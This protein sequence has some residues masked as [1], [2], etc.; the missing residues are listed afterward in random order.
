MRNRRRYGRRGLSTIVT[1]LMLVVAVSMIG[2]ALVAW[3]NSSFATQQ[4]DISNQTTNRINLVKETFI[5]EDVWFY[6]NVTG[7]YAN[8][9]IRNTGDNGLTISNIYVNNTEAWDDGEDILVDGVA[10]IDIQTAWET[11]KPQSIWVRTD[12]GADMKQVWKS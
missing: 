7:N 11:G 8:V 9:T 4:R 6:S 2:V 12:R 3:S 5:I 10:I 1:S